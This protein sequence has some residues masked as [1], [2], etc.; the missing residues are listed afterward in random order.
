MGMI[1]GPRR[2]IVLGTS[3]AGKIASLALAQRMDVLRVVGPAPLHLGADPGALSGKHAHSHAFLPRFFSEIEAVLP[4]LSRAFAESGLRR[5]RASRAFRGP[6]PLRALRLKAMRWQVDD[7][8]TRHFTERLSDRLW[9]VQV[10]GARIGTHVSELSLQDGRV[11]AVDPDTLVV[12]GMGAGS[13]LM[14]QLSRQ[15]GAPSIEDAPS[16]IGYVTQIFRLR[17]RIGGFL[18]PD[19]VAD[20]SDH[21]G[22]A[23]VTLYAGAGGWFSITLAWDIRH[24]AT[25]DLLRDTESVIAFARR[26]PGVA[27][28]IDAAR[29]V[30]PARRYI[31]PR[32]RWC[33]PIL[34]AGA[35]PANY[36]AI[37]DALTTT[38]PTLG[39][40]CSWLASHVRILVDALG[41]GADWRRHF[42]EGVTEEQRGFF[43]LSVATGAPGVIDPPPPLRPEKGPLQ[44]LLSPL[45]D[46]RH[47]AFIREHVVKGSTL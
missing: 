43:D 1:A 28:W 31:N 30:G 34:A 8:V 20:C 22:Q 2:A 24:R 42:V 10:D 21:L 7:V 14:R 47:H 4:Q 19:P 26:S 15:P 23:F 32:N 37:G 13:P 27:R 3:L 12:D 17:S 18:L 40:G 5:V 9:T 29:P 46:K 36:V 33:L 35:C 25:S 6:A 16:H 11:L 39:A 44:V 45:T 41:A 38:A